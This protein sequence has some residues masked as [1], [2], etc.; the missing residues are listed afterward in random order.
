MK[1]DGEI[2]LNCKG[3]KLKREISLG[4]FKTEPNQIN[5]NQTDGYVF[6]FGFNQY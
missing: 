4:I 2:L 5:N 1:K 6:G 3:E